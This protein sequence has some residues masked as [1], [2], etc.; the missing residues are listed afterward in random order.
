[1][2][3]FFKDKPQQPQQPPIAPSTAE[4][5]QYQ[6]Q[7][8]EEER[9]NRYNLHGEVLAKLGIFLD[10]AQH[11]DHLPNIKSEVIT[12][13]A[14]NFEFETQGYPYSALFVN[15]TDDNTNINVNVLGVV[16]H[17]LALSQGVNQVNFIDNTSIASPNK[18]I[19]VVLVRSTHPL[20]K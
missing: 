11:K 3:D 15:A 14:S 17:T 7:A 4:H 19:T 8:E 18:N 16:N 20:V 12:L 5:I 10:K 1:M 9:Q 6:Q 13:S 2:F